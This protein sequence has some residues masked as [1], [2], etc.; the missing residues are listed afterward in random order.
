MAVLSPAR[1]RSR[2]PGEPIAAESGGGRSP[3]TAA[4]AIPCRTRGANAAAGQVSA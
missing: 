2:P 3:P 4:P 1:R